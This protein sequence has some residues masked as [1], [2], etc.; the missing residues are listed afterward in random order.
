MVRL[1][2]LVSMRN[3][4]AVLATSSCMYSHSVS[5]KCEIGYVY[6]RMHV[7]SNPMLCMCKLVI[8]TVAHEGSIPEAHEQLILS[9]KPSL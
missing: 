2:Q 9:R 7:V 4:S 5:P 8:L 1:L 6:L 3:Q